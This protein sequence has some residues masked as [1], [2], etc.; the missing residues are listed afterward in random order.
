[1]FSFGIL[2]CNLLRQKNEIRTQTQIIHAWI[3]C[4]RFQC[5]HGLIHVSKITLN[6][7]NRYISNCRWV[8]NINCS[9]HALLTNNWC[10]Y[11]AY[12]FTPFSSAKSQNSPNFNTESIKIL[13][14]KL[15]TYTTSGTPNIFWICSISILWK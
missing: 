8:L 5:Y 2:I 10:W 13:F 14:N 3:K 7:I 12:A 1:M 11:R 9:L 6:W 4:V 15:D